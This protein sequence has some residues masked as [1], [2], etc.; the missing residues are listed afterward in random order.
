MFSP[1]AFPFVC[2]FFLSLLLKDRNLN[3][4]FLIRI[5]YP[6]GTDIRDKLEDAGVRT[7]KE[8][9]HLGW[10]EDQRIKWKC[11][12]SQEHGKSSIT[13]ISKITL[14]FIEY[15]ELMPLWMLYYLAQIF[16][17]RKMQS[18]SQMLGSQEW[19][20]FSLDSLHGL[21]LLKET[22]LPRSLAPILVW[23]HWSN[24]WSKTHFHLPHI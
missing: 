4:L 17:F 24:D 23:Y 10:Q 7:T 1:S 3:T 14:Q 18:H 5:I 11:R 13:S 2:F 15:D 12:V 19:Q 16:L 21:V 8:Q 6:L 9:T 22:K 20:V